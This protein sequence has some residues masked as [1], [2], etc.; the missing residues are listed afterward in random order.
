MFEP[1]SFCARLK[2]VVLVLLVLT[3]AGCKF[4]LPFLR[5][6]KRAPPPAEAALGCD[7]A[8]AACVPVH[9][10]GETTVFPKHRPGSIA[11][12]GAPQTAE[13]LDVTTPAERKA[14]QAGRKGQHE[15][16]LGKTIASLGAVSDPGFWLKTP[17]VTKAAPGRVI[18]ASN[19]NSIKLVLMPKDGPKGGGSQISL[20]AMRALE[21]PLTTLPE[22]IV[23]RLRK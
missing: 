15:K 23:F 13:V 16:K 17:L 12:V 2:P 18:W 10:P 7:P 11:A 14:A 3:L 9:Q 21:I 19:G 1:R 6:A 4:S 20:A 5:V 8:N 22:L